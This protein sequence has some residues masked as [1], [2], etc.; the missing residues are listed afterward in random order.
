MGFSENANLL[1][2]MALHDLITST[3]VYANDISDFITRV[4]TASLIPL[5]F[6]F[7]TINSMLLLTQYPL[8]RMYA[9]DIFLSDLQT[10]KTHYQTWGNDSL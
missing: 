7:Y 4:R 2:A 9:R 8:G 1:S 6:V 10:H 5:Q 3:N